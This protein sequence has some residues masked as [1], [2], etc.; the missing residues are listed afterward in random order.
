SLKFFPTPGHKFFGADTLAD[1]FTGQII[2][3]LIVITFVAIF[4]LR[5]WI[6]QN[7]RPGV[8]DDNEDVPAANA[9][10]D[11]VLQVPPPLAPLQAEPQEGVIRFAPE[12]GRREM[13]AR[14]ALRR[15]QLEAIRALDELRAYDREA[16]EREQERRER[17][18]HGVEDDQPIPRAIRNGRSALEFA[19]VRDEARNEELD[20]YAV[21]KQKKRRGKERAGENEYEE[22]EEDEA[23]TQERKRRRNF[24]RRFKLEQAKSNGARRRVYLAGF[25][26]APPPAMRS[27][28]SAK[29]SGNGDLLDAST[30]SPST[31]HNGSPQLPSSSSFFPNCQEFFFIYIPFCVSIFDT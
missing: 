16:R 5:E 11:Q 12:E 7:A 13:H 28:D 21:M 24:A 20:R 14:Y 6:A 25:P 10:Q 18:E 1:I 23:F 31:S 9:P 22:D 26:A 15:Q 17:R 8:F 4:L 30:S 29:G 27:N 3:S 2:A 19:P